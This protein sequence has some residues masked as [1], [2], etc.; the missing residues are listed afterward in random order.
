M[1]NNE[2]LVSLATRPQHERSEIARMGQK[3]ATEVKNKKKD[4][5]ECLEILLS[6]DITAK[7]G[8]VMSGAE[9]IAAKLFENALKGNVR[10]FEVLRDSAGQK[11]VEKLQ[12]ETIN[13]EVF[14]DIQNELE[15]RRIERTNKE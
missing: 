7:N 11:P 12:V 4:I 13:Q 8:E 3:A 5:R 2:N 6:K 14:D 1:A 9:A 15:K 10:A